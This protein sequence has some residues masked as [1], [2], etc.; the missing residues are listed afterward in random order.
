M[1][2]PDVLHR[3]G[4]H[5]VARDPLLAGLVLAAAVI[6][7]RAADHS[8]W[9]DGMPSLVPGAAMGVLIGFLLARAQLPDGPLLTIAVFLVALAAGGVTVVFFLHGNP[10]VRLDEYVL[11]AREWLRLALHARPIYDDAAYVTLVE[12]LTGM[13]GLIA[14]WSVLRWAAFWLATIPPGV[15]L[16]IAVSRL[17]G[18]SEASFA[19]Y[20][21]IAI[22]V[23]AR[24][25]AHDRAAR[26]GRPDRLTGPFST[27][28]AGGLATMVVL[29][30]WQWPTPGAVGPLQSWVDQVNGPFG[31]GIARPGQG[32]LHDFSAELPFVGN[33]RLGDTV[34]AEATFNGVAPPYLRARSYDTYTSQAWSGSPLTAQ[35]L[36]RLDALLAD[37]GSRGLPSNT[38]R[39]SATITSAEGSELLL[40]PNLPAGASDAPAGTSA[41]YLSATP[42]SDA[43]QLR[44]RV[45]RGATYRTV[46]YSSGASSAQLRAVTWGELARA[47]A[48]PWLRNYYLRLPDTV[49]ARTR[50]LARQ[51][52]QRAPTPFDAALAI[53]SYLRTIPYDLNIPAPPAGQDP[54][55]WFLF[56]EQ[57]GFCDYD[58]SAMAVML[59]S[60][61]IPARVAVG[62]ALNEKQGDTYIIREKDA[63]AWV[64]AYF[65]GYGW[66]TFNPTPSLP[67]LSYTPAP[68]QTPLPGQTA[69]P[70]PGPNDSATATPTRAPRDAGQ[71]DNAGAGPSNGTPWA[72]LTVLG[73]LVIGL[74]M[75]AGTAAFRWARV[76]RVPERAA[77]LAWER[78]Q[79]LSVVLRFPRRPWQTP[80]EYARALRR[81]IPD[82]RGVEE[83][84]D[85]Y[86][87]ASYGRRRHDPAQARRI[88]RTW[89]RLARRL[90]FWRLG[91]GR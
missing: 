23:L 80:R 69:T 82:A 51:L 20:I 62:Y 13:A 33:V 73:L 57:R 14:T 4:A 6:V 44:G 70:T 87:E 12:L 71:A 78:L 81:R 35:P 89:L 66:V 29:V 39:F 58:A 24:L 40:T 60:L 7:A 32:Y 56:V 26:S 90:I 84:A 16:A 36:S 30:A 37:P 74:G 75:V 47:A 53:E 31:G 48:A 45:A 83:L 38:P 63:H 64:E 1:A 68:S 77:V 11:H 25:R 72:G 54:V 3:P 50:L 46:G 34:V 85:R 42:P 79:W 59:R 22:V 67:E 76:D 91:G 65:P 10:V 17:D 88:S 9:I 86:A 43:V 41:D 49:S 15:M 8:A 2:R 52:V 19:A 55:D 28:L 21:V 27:V 18:V 5:A 61:G